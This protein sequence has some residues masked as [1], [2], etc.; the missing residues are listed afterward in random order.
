MSGKTR[1]S[2]K[3]RFKVS[4]NGKVIPYGKPG[5]RHL[6]GSKS[7][8]KLRQKKSGSGPVDSIKIQRNL[9]VVINGGS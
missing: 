8:K 6:A 3:K 9:R 1:K 4:A 7:R 2:A 5:R